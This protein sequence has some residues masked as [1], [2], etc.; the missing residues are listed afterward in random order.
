MEEIT[1]TL[2]LL[3]DT[4]SLI[5]MLDEMFYKKK[6]NQK[7]EYK[8]LD[9]LDKRFRKCKEMLKENLDDLETNLAMNLNLSLALYTHIQ[10]VT[11]EMEKL[12]SEIEVEE[13]KS[14]I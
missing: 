14:E 12:L 6:F 5:K 2:K 8:E 11:S 13:V 7:D 3:V 1:K 9:L 4:E 10:T